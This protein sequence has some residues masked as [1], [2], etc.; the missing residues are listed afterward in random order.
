MN[1]I[2]VMNKII[3]YFSHKPNSIK[4]IDSNPRKPYFSISKNGKT[5][6]FVISETGIENTKHPDIVWVGISS[7]IQERIDIERTFVI[8]ID[9]AN[10]ETLILF[11]VNSQENLRPNYQGQLMFDVKRSQNYGSQSFKADDIENLIKKIEDI[12]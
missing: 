3:E 2:E 5:K 10:N 12:I 8:T 11:P 7:N 9:Y 6:F 1:K 4:I